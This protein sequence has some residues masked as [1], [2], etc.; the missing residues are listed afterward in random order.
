MSTD[1]V[2]ILGATSAIAQAYAR[3]RAAAGVRFVL[4]GRREER[5]KVVAA[6]LVTRGA[7]S[8]EPLLMDLSAI[9]AIESAVETI[10]ARFGPPQEIVLAYGILGEQ[11]V[12]ERDVAAAQAALDVNFTSAALW[13][14]AFLKGRE[15]TQPL[16]TIVIGSVAGDR[17]RR[18]NFIYGAAKAGI[19][20]FVQGLAHAYAGTPAR[21]VL[22]KPGFVDTPMTAG[23]VKSGPLWSTPDRVATDIERAVR[24]GARVVYTPWFWRPIMAVIRRLPWFVFRRLK[25]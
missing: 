3:R 21:F 1:L 8:A 25:I 10:H 13:Q 15:A 9:G 18:T 23:F 6:D 17:G 12:L 20:I 14:L 4:A 7:A 24:R 22:V 19:D 2:V 16:T 11:T 5:L